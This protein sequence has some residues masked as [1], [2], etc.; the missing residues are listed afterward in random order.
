MRAALE[1]AKQAESKAE[2][3]LVDT[4]SSVE[5]AKQKKLELGSKLKSAFGVRDYDGPGTKTIHFPLPHVK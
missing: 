5:Q 3:E 2:A 4:A 1:T